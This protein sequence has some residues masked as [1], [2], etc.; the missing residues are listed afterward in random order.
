MTSDTAYF[1]FFNP[2]NVELV[3]KV[4]DGRAVNGFFWLFYAALTDLEYWI[5]VT[6]T[7]TG[8]TKT[9]H[10]APFHQASVSEF[11]AF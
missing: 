3:L 8:A 2:N 1:F 9:Y 10:N 6:D 5:T 4:L 7:Q 11:E